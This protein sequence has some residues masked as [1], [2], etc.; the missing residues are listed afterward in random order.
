MLKIIGLYIFILF[1]Y[2][3]IWAILFAFK[4]YDAIFIVS[5]YLWL[6]IG[7]LLSIFFATFG[8]IY[9]VKS[10]IYCNY[11]SRHIIY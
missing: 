9:F 2:L 4:K 7:G 5:S 1:V 8:S 3:S 10:E 11:C 6:G